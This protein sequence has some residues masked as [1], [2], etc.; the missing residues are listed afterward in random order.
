MADTQAFVLVRKGDCRAGRGE[1]AKQG[2]LCNRGVSAQL[3]AS[4]PC[5][6]VFPGSGVYGGSR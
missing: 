6:P 4:D 3:S 5:P 1:S 2:G